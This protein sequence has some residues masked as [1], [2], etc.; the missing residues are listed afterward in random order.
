MRK[1]PT[2]TRKAS[3]SRKP[4]RLPSWPTVTELGSMAGRFLRDNTGSLTLKLGFAIF[5]MFLAAGLVVDLGRAYT[6]RARLSYALDAAGLAVGASQG[7]EAE[8]QQVMLDYFA[9]NYPEE[10]MG[11]PAEPYMTIDG[12]EINLSATAD[13]D[14]TFMRVVGLDVV[15]VGSDVA[16]LKET[17]GFEVAMVL[18]NTGSMRSGGKMDALKDAAQEFIDTVY[19][20]ETTLEDVWVSVVPYTATVNIGGD[21]T[22]WLDS[23]DPYFASPGPFAP[24]EW[25]GCVNARAEPLDQDDTPPASEGFTSYH[26]DPEVDNDWD[27]GDASTI[28]ESNGAKNNGTGPNLGCGPEITP[29][30]DQRATIEAAVDEMLPWHRGG[31]T[32]NLGLVWGWRALSPEWQGEWGGDTPNNLPMSYDEDQMEKVVIMMTDG[33]NQFYDWP[34]HGPTG[35]GPEGSDH[36]AYGRL[37]EFGF[38]SLGDGRDEV[39]ARFANICATMK[40]EGIIIYTITFGSTPDDDTQALYRDCATT[41]DHYFH[42]PSNG[43]LKDAFKAI[44]TELSNLRIAS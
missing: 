1:T 27:P 19:K 31:T 12:D 21:R 7:T 37:E 43:Q 34:S 24:V 28:D 18:D 10:A 40:A 22:S 20:S 11:V 29:L 15:T 33:Q 8:L 13:M 38:S 14:T 6:V 32:G 3:Q 26:Y 30:V 23:G 17:T 16:I 9:A 36:T 25:K 44:G 5:P 41:P 35:A 39:D 2:A 4:D 42:S